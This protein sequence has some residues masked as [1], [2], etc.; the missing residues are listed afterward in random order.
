MNTRRANARRMEE[1]N[2]NQEAPQTWIDPLA[3]SNVEVRSD[4]QMLVQAL[5]TQAQVVTH[6]N[7]YVNS[8]AS[9]VRDFSQINPPKFY[10][11]KVKDD[12]Q[13][14]IDE[15]YKVLVIMGVSSE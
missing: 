2:V 10:G 13:R 14:F 7:P 6:V 9:R 1:D 4:F 3:M 12:S 11:S 8:A 5:T 15:V